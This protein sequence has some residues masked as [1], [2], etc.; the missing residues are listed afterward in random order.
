MLEFWSTTWGD[1]ATIV[2]VLISIGGLGWAI[3]EAHGAKAA[4]VAAKLAAKDTR[5]QIAR[6]LQVVDLQRAIAL[7][8]RIKNLHDDD[9]WEAA[10]EHYQTLRA[11]L[12]D[13]IVRSRE[14][15]SDGRKELTTSRAFLR[16]MED[17]AREKGSRSISES[18]RSRINQELNTIQSVPEELASY[19]GF[20]G[21]QGESG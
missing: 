2:G 1:A 8:E 6:H 18:E 14:G 17:L 21:S 10:Q 11:M 20:G 15:Q 3:W 13:V 12:S 4:S 5:E 9:R 19:M 7:I 16:S